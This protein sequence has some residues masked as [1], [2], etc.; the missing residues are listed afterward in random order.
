MITAVKHDRNHLIIIKNGVI[1]L[2]WPYLKTLHGREFFLPI[3]EPTTRGWQRRLGFTDGGYSIFLSIIHRLDRVLR[4]MFGSLAAKCSPVSL[5]L[6]GDWQVSCS[7]ASAKKPQD[8]SKHCGVE[9]WEG[10]PKKA[11]KA[12]QTIKYGVRPPKRQDRILKKS[13]KEVKTQIKRCCNPFVTSFPDSTAS[14]CRNTFSLSIQFTPYFSCCHIFQL[15]LLSK[16]QKTKI[17]R[18]GSRPAVR[19]SLLR[20]WGVTVVH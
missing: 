17:N 19:R 12:K 5:S 6:F 18:S 4:E 10:P 20:D 13:C 2:P 15:N 9:G 11:W 3:L 14:P 16:Q 8:L 1:T 7:F